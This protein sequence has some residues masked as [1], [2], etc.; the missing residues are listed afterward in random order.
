MTSLRNAVISLMR[1]LGEGNI[2]AACRRF[3]AQPTAAL[4]ALGV[5]TNIE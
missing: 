5:T 1:S 3:S 4:A 2:A